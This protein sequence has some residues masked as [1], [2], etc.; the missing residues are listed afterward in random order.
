MHY[1][2]L[3]PK[4]R[5]T[6]PFITFFIHEF[7]SFSILDD[8]YILYDRPIF[9]YTTWVHGQNGGIRLVG[10]KRFA[11]MSAKPIFVTDLDYYNG[12]S[13][14]FYFNNRTSSEVCFLFALIWLVYITVTCTLVA[15]SDGISPFL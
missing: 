4:L 6:S 8:I 9:L 7:T 15:K 3:L 14:F 10:T 13:I 12:F 5:K 1:I 11:V 2:D